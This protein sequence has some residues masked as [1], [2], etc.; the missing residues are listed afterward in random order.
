MADFKPKMKAIAAKFGT[1]RKVCDPSRVMRL[2]GFLHRKDQ[3]F[4]VDFARDLRMAEDADRPGYTVDQIVTALRL[5]IQGKGAEGAHADER[6]VQAATQAK[7]KKDFAPPPADTMRAMLEHLFD[8]G[9]FEDRTGVETDDQG[10]L[11]KL[12]WI[13]TGMALK[14][15][16]GDDGQDLWAVTHH[17]ERAYADAPGQWASFASDRKPGQITIATIIK[18]ARDAGFI[19]AASQ[20]T[21]TIDLFLAFMPTHQYIFAPTGDLWPRQASTA[22]CLKSSSEGAPTGNPR[23]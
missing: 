5:D 6:W 10:R 12:S 2:P 4:L 8:R 18:A 20:E 11:V 7:N 14:L 17:D 13:E 16:Y 15:A 9:R 19:D 1:D 3:P 23:R 22:D 21:I